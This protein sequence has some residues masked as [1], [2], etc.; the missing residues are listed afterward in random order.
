ML[1]KKVL[2]VEKEKDELQS[3]LQNID[4]E[5]KTLKGQKINNAYSAYS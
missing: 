1:D 3:K 5:L 4:S 2:N